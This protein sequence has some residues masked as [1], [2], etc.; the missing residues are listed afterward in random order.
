VLLVNSW[1]KFEY[2]AE[3]AESGN[4][5]DLPTTRYTE[6]KGRNKKMQGWSQEGIKRF[7]DFC[8]FVKADRESKLGEEF[9]KAFLKFHQDEAVRKKAVRSSGEDE[10]DDDDEEMGEE[11]KEMA[12]NQMQELSEM[13]DDDGNGDDMPMGWI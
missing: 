12:W 2:L 7:N 13:N 11:P 6:K 9:E 10:E 8:V 4:K 5:V 3:H 1:D